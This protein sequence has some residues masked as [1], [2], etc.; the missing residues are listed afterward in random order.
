HITIDRPPTHASIIGWKIFIF[1]LNDTMTIAASVA[2]KV[3]TIQGTKI[4]V[5]LAEC[6]AALTAITLTGIKVSPDACRQRNMICALLA[7][8]LLGFNSCRLSIAFNP[9]G[10]AALSKPSRLA[11]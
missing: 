2:T 6:K 9:K 3:T 5:G 8:F 1:C 7:V 4:S 11:E 10:V